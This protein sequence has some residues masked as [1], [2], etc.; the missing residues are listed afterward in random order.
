MAAFPAS[1]AI[2]A[3]SQPQA[4]RGH[5]GALTG[6]AHNVSFQRHRSNARRGGLGRNDDPVRCEPDVERRPYDRQ[7]GSP[8]ASGR[9]SGRR[10]STPW[11]T[12]RPGRHHAQRHQVRPRPAY[13]AR[14]PTT[15]L[16]GIPAV[17]LDDTAS[18]N[19]ADDDRRAS[20]TGTL[21]PVQKDHLRI[22]TTGVAFPPTDL[23]PT[24]R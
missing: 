24:T 15:Q 12:T 22:T 17:C 21:S 6:L 2:I 14:T 18:S 3:A 8:E 10:S 20:T 1:G 9:R 4:V 19:A 13:T 5:A 16:M 23:P 11:Q 7:R